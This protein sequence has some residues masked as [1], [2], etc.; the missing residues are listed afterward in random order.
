MTRP[1]ALIFGMYHH[2]VNFYQVCSNYTSWAKNGPTARVKFYIGLY[3]E[4]MKKSCLKPQGIEPWYVA[5]TSGPLP[6]LFK[7]FTWGPLR[8]HMFYIGLYKENVK[9][10]CLKPQGLEP[11]HLVCSII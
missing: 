3:R 4:N 10:S 5:S 6:S 1:R 11:R 7:L 9:K 8:G 2:L